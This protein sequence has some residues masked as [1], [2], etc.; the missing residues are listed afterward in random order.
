VVNPEHLIGK[1]IDGHYRL[2][3]YIGSGTFGHVFEASETFIHGDVSRVALKLIYPA[4]AVELTAVRREVEG[5]ARLTHDHVI[6]Y[7]T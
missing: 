3:R 2:T 5:L 7:R 4:S 1:V 6:A